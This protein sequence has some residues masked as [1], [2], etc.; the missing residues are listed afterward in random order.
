MIVFFH[1][2][3][4]LMPLLKY[5]DNDLVVEKGKENLKWFRL[6]KEELRGKSIRCIAMCCYSTLAVHH[7][8]YKVNIDLTSS[9]YETSC[10]S[11]HAPGPH[12]SAFHH[13]NANSFFK[14]IQNKT[15]YD[16]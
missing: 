14:R 15:E 12:S 3:A 11:V 9:L 13:I 5:F 6:R 8:F 2:K 7:P 10:L 16:E 1:Q 4:P